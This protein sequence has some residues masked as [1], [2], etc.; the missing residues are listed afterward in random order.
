MKTLSK[1]VQSFREHS[2]LYVILTAAVLLEL[3]SGIQYYYTHGLLEKE[4]ES[5]AENELTMKAILIKSTLNAAESIV[6]DHLWDIHRH[7]ASPDSLFNVAS[8]LT[9]AHP[10]F[11]SSAIALRPHYY[12]G[13]GRLFEPWARR[14]GDSLRVEQ[15]GGD[16]HDY[17]T[18]EF[19]ERVV[20]HDS[21][22]WTAPYIDEKGS[23]GL[24]TTYAIPLHDASGE[25]IGVVG[26]D[27]DL[28]WMG[29]TLNNRNKY[30]SSFALLLTEDGQLIAGPSPSKVKSE[31]VEAIVAAVNDSSISR[32]LSSSGRTTVIEFTPRV[33]DRDASV[34]YANMRG[35]PHWQLVS[36][37]YDDEVYAHLN[38]MR[39]N[40]LMLTL[41][42]LLLL[43]YI[44]Y[45]SVANLNRL[46]E[47][48][49]EQTRINGE[50]RIAKNIQQEMLPEYNPNYPNRRDLDVFGML[51]PAKQ[52][53]GD[54]Y[55]CFV[56]DEKLFFCIGDVSGKGMPSALVMAVTHALFRS[57]ATH[58]TN[59]SRIMKTLN[60]SLS[61]GN[62]S[63]M[64][65]TFFTGVLDL[66]TGRLRYCN[67]GH[68]CPYIIHG[69]DVHELPAVAN[70]PLGL[71]GD[72]DYQVQDD[73]LPPGAMLFLYTDG[74]TEA[75]SSQRELFG[76][77][78]VRETL[79][80]LASD[81]L[82]AERLSKNMNE[83]VRVFVGDAEQSDD[84]TMLAIR[85]T[86][87]AERSLLHESLALTNN[88]SEVDRL[89]RFVKDF[90][91][92]IG[93]DKALASNLRLAIEEAVVNVM[94]YAYP[95]ETTGTIELEADI[96]VS[97]SAD[98]AGQQHLCVKI[99]DSGVAFDP[100]EAAEADT[101]LSAED[102]P[103]GGLGIFLVRE[104]MDSINYEREDGRNILTMKKSVNINLKT[105][106][107][108]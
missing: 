54:L 104:L 105:D 47:A 67:G 52:V 18:F 27:V 20:E 40:I 79:E 70:L 88:V 59:P 85:Y 83:S 99:I 11:I 12:P 6:S 26:A 22:A 28:S 100:T 75:R 9:K 30:P 65:V 68:D 80:S 103:I 37:N 91:E 7:L 15:I 58:E 39:L 42:G 3:I 72:F 49:E 25:C 95:K 96:M 76:D 108:K 87:E 78:R 36:V 17:T 31:E 101:T 102:R 8:R 55:D 46:H 19:Y 63:N 90:T 92:R 33:T 73:K 2:S 45:R 43:G 41:V 61:E 29:D 50:L 16:D 38:R 56:R 21:A 66:P 69:A 48:S 98:G 106:K 34:F 5:H 1:I 57:A 24:I 84:L 62:E 77:K 51:E 23:G 32:C 35:K 44:L 89:S 82:T 14:V 64:F 74:L 10:Q 13:K 97:S 60:A 93:L 94:N 86:P 53:G 4:L 81:G 107:D 71:F